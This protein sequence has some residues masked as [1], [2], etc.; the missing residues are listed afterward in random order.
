MTPPDTTSALPKRWFVFHL[1]V[2]FVAGALCHLSFAPYEFQII[3][4]LTIALLYAQFTFVKPLTNKAHVY[5]GLAYGFGLFITGLRWVH[6]SLDTFGGL[7]LVVTIALMVLLSLYLALF[8]ALAAYAF[9]RLKNHT[10]SFNALLFSVLWCLSEYL[11]GELLTGFPWLWLGYSQ[12][13]GLISQAAS[14]VGVLGLSFIILLLA[15]LSIN[16]LKSCRISIVL[17]AITIGI[18]AWLS[19]INSI[20]TNG[21]TTDLALI[22]G[23]IEQSA[24]WKQEAMWPT[25]SRYMELT[26]QNFDA[27]LIIWPEA[28]MPAVEAWLEDYLHSVDKEALRQ[29]SAIITGIISRTTSIESEQVSQN[30][31]NA[32]ITLGQHDEVEQREARYTEN[33]SN[34]YYKHQLLPIG[35]FVPFAQ[36][37]RPLAPLFNLPMS[38]FVRGDAVQAN[39]SAK[40]IKLTAAICYEIAF[41]QLVRQNL[42]PDTDMILTVSNDAWFGRSIGPHQHM[43]LAQMRAIELGRPVIRVTNTGITAIVNPQ[44]IITDRLNQFEEGVLRANVKSYHGETYYYRYG[45]APILWFSTFFFAL[46]LFLKRQSN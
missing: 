42:T 9:A 16:L 15:S 34:R 32:L 45:N 12:T 8:P 17:L 30:Y 23:N 27:D 2:A 24:K 20:S 22:Q 41:S 26:R 14:I 33:H 7:P 11:R 21:K 25:I 10:P 1:F 4:P 38:S 37:L 44:G 3:A 31:Y 40:G 36:L 29:N 6:V 18:S 5:L 39:L 43:Q 46:A 13:V 35:E 19:T 28:A